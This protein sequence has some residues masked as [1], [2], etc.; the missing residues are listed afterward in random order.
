[1]DLTVE[2][3]Q[4]KF[5]ASSGFDYIVIYI[6]NKLKESPDFGSHHYLTKK[7]VC[8]LIE[9]LKENKCGDSWIVDRLSNMILLMEGKEKAEF[10]FW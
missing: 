2:T 10:R 7:E 3:K 6:C 5:S 4:Y 1:M 9:Y 8:D